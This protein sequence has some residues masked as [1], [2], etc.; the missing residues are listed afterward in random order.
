MNEHGAADP[1]VRRADRNRHGLAGPGRPQGADARGGGR[2]L[3]AAVEDDVD[4]RARLLHGMGDVHPPAV[5]VDL[6]RALA[7]V[8][9][10][11]LTKSVLASSGAEAVEAALKTAP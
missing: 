1:A 10:G 4:D 3:A 5:K 8:A 2:D 6:L 11:G 7:E 9:P